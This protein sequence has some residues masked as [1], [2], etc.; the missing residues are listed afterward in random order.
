MWN[1]VSP[2]VHQM[3]AEKALSVCVGMQQTVL[4]REREKSNKLILEEEKK[5]NMQ[6]STRRIGMT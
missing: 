6:Q 4:S 3:T 5:K 2:A 1:K